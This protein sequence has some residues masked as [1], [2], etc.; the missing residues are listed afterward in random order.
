[1]AKKQLSRKDLRK[2]TRLLKKSKKVEH[3]AK[4]AKTGS[5]EVKNEKKAGPLSKIL[6]EG[7]V[8]AS[9]SS[10]SK[11]KLD[12]SEKKKRRNLALEFSG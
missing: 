9:S 8:R 4:K 7:K 10:S 6:K 11:S 5:S 1:M 12:Q 2:A 3:V